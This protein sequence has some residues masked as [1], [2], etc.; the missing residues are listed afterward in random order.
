LNSLLEVFSRKHGRSLE[1]PGLALNH[2]P[3]ISREFTIGM[4]GLL[5][6][7]FAAALVWLDLIIDEM[8]I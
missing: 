8:G 4:S 1:L 7:S 2:V 5:S 6:A 3:C